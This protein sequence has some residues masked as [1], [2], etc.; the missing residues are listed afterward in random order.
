MSFANCLTEP[1]VVG[2]TGEPE[3][4]FVKGESDEP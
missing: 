1:S 2:L 4:F 3:P